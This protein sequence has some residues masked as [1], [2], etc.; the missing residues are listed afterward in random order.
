MTKVILKSSKIAEIPPVGTKESMPRPSE[1]WRKK[2]ESPP[3]LGLGIVLGIL[4]QSLTYMSP[5]TRLRCLQYSWD[6]ETPLH[7]PSFD[8]GP[9]SLFPPP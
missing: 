7:S 4:G 2:V 6:R 8:V 3:R 1:W 9:L 5:H